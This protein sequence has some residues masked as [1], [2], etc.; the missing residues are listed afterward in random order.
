MSFLLTQNAELLLRKLILLDMNDV[1]YNRRQLLSSY[2]GMKLFLIKQLTQGCP[3][4]RD[5]SYLMKYILQRLIANMPA[6]LYKNALALVSTGQCATAIVHLKQAIIRGHLP[7]RA[8]KAWLLIREGVTKDCIGALKAWL[9]IDDREDVTED[10]NGAF[11]LAKEGARLGCHHCQGVMA[12]CYRYGYGIRIDRARSS[13]LAFESSW[14]G[15]RYGQYVLGLFYQY[16]AGGVAQDGA[17]ALVL[18]RLAAAQNLDEAQNDLGDMYYQGYGVAQ[19][20]AEAL[21]LYQLAAAQGH[22]QALYWVADFHEC[23]IG[24]P[25]N[26]AEA[27]RWYR[28]AQAAGNPY[29]AAKLQ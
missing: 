26:K 2:C 19:D 20:L 13:E 12:W 8:L 7:S 25:K 21:R 6:S 14:T 27:I 4:T 22:P 16:S 18:F 9:L 3:S 11:E 1:P 15:S 24:V 28:R 5:K 29:A 10:C 23:G 17:Q